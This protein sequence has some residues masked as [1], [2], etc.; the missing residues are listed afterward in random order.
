MKQKT[1]EPPRYLNKLN[2]ID[3]STNILKETSDEFYKKKTE[4][5]LNDFR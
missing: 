4:R 2:R 5:N 1:A 3:M